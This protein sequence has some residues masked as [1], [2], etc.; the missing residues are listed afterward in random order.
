MT[1]SGDDRSYNR[2]SS[3]KWS[4]CGRYVEC[5]SGMDACEALLHE[6]QNLK[7]PC[8]SAAKAWCNDVYDWGCGCMWDT[9][10]R[11]GWAAWGCRPNVRMWCTDCT[12]F[13][14]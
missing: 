13:L 7:S 12:V 8:A 14:V 11:V 9:Q 5:Q 1:G 3:V 6:R 4:G 10:G 2:P